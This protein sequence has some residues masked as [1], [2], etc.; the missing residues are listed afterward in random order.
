VKNREL[1][2]QF[3][4][5]ERLLR[6]N[7]V[8]GYHDKGPMG[9][10][11]RGQGRILTLLRS[12]PEL[13]QKDL[14]ITLDMT[15]QSLGELLAKLERSGY[16]ARSPSP[17]DRRA[18]NIYL[19]EAGKA[20]SENPEGPHSFE[21]LF[22][23]LS[24]EQRTLFSECMRKLIERLEQNLKESESEREH[25]RGTMVREQSDFRGGRGFDGSR[26]KSGHDFE[27]D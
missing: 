2:D 9:T 10:R 16:I 8:Q 5:F 24:E 14:S 21:E 17:V 12:R 3:S 27:E 13:S 11:R 7:D 25:R 20:A 18:M 26:D 6:R 4:R 23:C 19:T 1:L 15:S 22:D